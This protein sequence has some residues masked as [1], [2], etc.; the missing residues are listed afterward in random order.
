MLIDATIN[1][2]YEP[3]E[4]GNRFPPSVRPAE[5]DIANAAKRWKEFGFDEPDG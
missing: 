1:L 2:E 3:D 4:D 5:D